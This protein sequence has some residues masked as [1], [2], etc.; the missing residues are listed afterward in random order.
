MRIST[1]LTM[2]QISLN[3]KIDKAVVGGYENARRNK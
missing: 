1:M 2:D 3:D